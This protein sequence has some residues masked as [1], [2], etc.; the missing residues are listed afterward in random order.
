MVAKAA[1]RR[2]QEIVEDLSRHRPDADVTQS[3]ITNEGSQQM[4]AQRFSA[5][6]AGAATDGRQ[7]GRGLAMAGLA[8]SVLLPAAGVVAGCGA[9]HGDTLVT[10]TVQSSPLLKVGECFNETPD[11]AAPGAEVGDG[12]NY[13]VACDQPHSDEVFAILGLSR[14]P[15]GKADTDGLTNRCKAEL[16]TYSPA[17]SSDPKVQ[18]VMLSPDTSW[19]YMDNHTSGCL[20]HF[21][22]NRVGSIKG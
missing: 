5:R 14:W 7:Y 4:F 20:A 2:Y 11:S 21:T 9:A 13:P 22:P 10:G 12:I 17:A 16:Q 3:K 1:M 18:V 8:I 6:V 19:K 15:T